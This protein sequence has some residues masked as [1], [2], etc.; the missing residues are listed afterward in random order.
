[1]ALGVRP[2]MIAR[3]VFLSCVLVVYAP[4]KPAIGVTIQNIHSEFYRILAGGI[5]SEA[6]N[7]RYKLDMRGADSEAEQQSQVEAFINERVKAIVIVPVDSKMIGSAMLE[8]NAA[9]IP[10]F[11]TDI[12]STSTS[13]DSER[14]A[15]IAS[16]NKEGGAKAARLMCERVPKSGLVA[17]IDQPEVSSV[18]DR[19]QG[20]TAGIKASCPGVTVKPEADVD[21]GVR[22]KDVRG[23]ITDILGRKGL[24]GIFFVNDESLLDFPDLYSRNPCTS[25]ILVGYDAIP[26]IQDEIKSG[27]V[28]GDAQQYPSVLGS[29]TIDEVRDYLRGTRLK[30]PFV[31]IP[32]GTFGPYQCGKGIVGAS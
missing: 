16:D 9:D 19:V 30:N 25:P 21:V 27:V 1:M 5:S 22:H 11:M 24:V 20:F 32:V 6:S 14:V 13:D 18:H 23:A 3:A 17:I 4:G 12:D 10:V 2:A 29:K 7:L 26:S 31:P 15:Y 8:A 28:Y